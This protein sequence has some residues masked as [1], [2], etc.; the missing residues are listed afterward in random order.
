MKECLL[1]GQ[2]IQPDFNG[3]LYFYSVKYGQNDYNVFVCD[4]CSSKIKPLPINLQLIVRGLMARGQWPHRSY[5]VD[6]TCTHKEAI[7][8]ATLITMPDALLNFNY[9]KSP[10]EKMDFLFLSLFS[11]QK[12]EGEYINV[13]CEEDN[14]YLKNYFTTPKECF[15]YLEALF[16]DGL[17]ERSPSS[18]FN[19]KTALL[20][21]TYK[22][23]NKAVQ[24]QENGDLSKKCFIAMAFNEVT[25][26]ARTAIKNAI[27]KSGF[28]ETI[29][30]ETHL[31]SNQT[32]P[33][34][35]FAAIKQCK[36]CI[37]DFTLHKNGVYFESGYALGL[38]KPVIYVCS[39][40]DFDN[41][42]FDIK[43]LQHII[44]ADTDELEN[45]LYDKIE[46][47]IK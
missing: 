34:A 24:L 4:R 15:F 23:L 22:G 5:L 18:Q 8:N 12:E 7:Q 6:E 41:S 40:D 30:D 1:T 2:T 21:I 25:K 45:L 13:S 20:R 17:I 29:I 9:P 33:D 27:K 3:S 37:A 32:I 39:K 11:S 36:F 16:A 19:Y 38:G 43:Q 10:S 46:A 31:M 26:P 42:H 28:E 47:W 35:I 14:F 44:Y